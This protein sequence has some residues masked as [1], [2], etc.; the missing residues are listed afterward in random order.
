MCR[1]PGSNRGPL[2]LQSH[3]LPTE[4]SRLCNESERHKFCQLPY[5]ESIKRIRLY[6]ILQVMGGGGGIAWVCRELEDKQ[7]LW[8]NNGP[9]GSLR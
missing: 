9:I 5:K 7:G 1:D 6:G 3:A 8:G 2:D 4:L